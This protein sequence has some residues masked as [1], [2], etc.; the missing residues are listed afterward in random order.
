MLHLLKACRFKL[1]KAEHSCLGT[2]VKC[3]GTIYVGEKWLCW[4]G[5]KRGPG[6]WADEWPSATVDDVEFFV[7]YVKQDS[8]LI[9]NNCSNQERDHFKLRKKR[10]KGG[11]GMESSL[12]W[13]TTVNLLQSSLFKKCV[14]MNAGAVTP[15]VG[16]SQNS[17]PTIPTPEKECENIPVVTRRGLR[18]S[19]R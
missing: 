11:A 3:K 12:N 9:E 5:I 13:L 19:T 16:G 18:N 7:P 15:V 1:E 6:G 2:I 8:L 17:V 4:S 10:A 14:F